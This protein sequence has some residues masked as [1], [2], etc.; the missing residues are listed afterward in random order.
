MIE[1]ANECLD[2]Q[3]D[4]CLSGAVFPTGK[5]TLISVNNINNKINAHNALNSF[6][7]EC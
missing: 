6:N 7:H 1:K 2:V 5:N 3:K 4:I